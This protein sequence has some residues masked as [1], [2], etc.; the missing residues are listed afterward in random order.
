MNPKIDQIKVHQ[1]EID[2]MTL[3]LGLDKAVYEYSSTILEEKTHV[4]SFMHLCADII[5]ELERLGIYDA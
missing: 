5:K 2:Q 3:T 1:I 4:R